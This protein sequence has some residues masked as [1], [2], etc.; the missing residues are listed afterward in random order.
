MC[1]ARNAAAV[2]FETIC[3]SRDD[4]LNPKPEMI[5]GAAR[6]RRSAL[7]DANRL[8]PFEVKDDK[9]TLFRRPAG[10]TVGDKGDAG[11]HAGAYRQRPP[12]PAGQ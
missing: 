3:S 7:L 5:A 12:L 8:H 6:R 10:G 1:F 9:S 2:V 4:A 11:A